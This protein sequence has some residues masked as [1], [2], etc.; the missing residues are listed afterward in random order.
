MSRGNRLRPGIHHARR[1]RQSRKKIREKRLRTVPVK[2]GPRKSLTRRQTATEAS[3]VRLVH[4]SRIVTRAKFSAIE[5]EGDFE[6]SYSQS[7]VAHARK[8]E[9]CFRP[10][11]DE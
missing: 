5:F 8:L 7:G 9:K 3:T 2:G 1:F 10:R 4:Q 6:R 11:L